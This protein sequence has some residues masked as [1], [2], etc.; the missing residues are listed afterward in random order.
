MY[1]LAFN[2]LFYSVC[3]R[4]TFASK[5]LFVMV[6]SNLFSVMDP[7]MIWL[8]AVDPLNKTSYTV[9][10]KGLSLHE[11]LS[12]S[13]YH[14]SWIKLFKAGWPTFC[15]PNANFFQTRSS[16]DAPTPSTASC[17][18]TLFHI[19]MVVYQVILLNAYGV[20][21]KVANKLQIY[22]FMGFF[23]LFLFHRLC[24]VR[25][26]IFYWEQQIILST[27]IS[28]ARSRFV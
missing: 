21:G 22:F 8:K 25:S 20:S 6:V 5:N 13:A 15:T 3:L 4:H 16:T 11:R 2:N 17:N 12:S 19:S 27:W 1:V 18:N 26:S 24:N 14:K 7:L 23:R 28:E 10:H 9:T